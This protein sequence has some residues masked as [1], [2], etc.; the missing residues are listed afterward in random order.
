MKLLGFFVVFFFF[1]SPK[2]D[3]FIH[4]YFI[5]VAW[6]MAGKDNNVFRFFFFSAL[7]LSFFFYIC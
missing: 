2:S 5:N 4:D 7:F 6:G 1:F 3:I